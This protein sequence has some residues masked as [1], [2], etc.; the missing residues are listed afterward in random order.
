MK[1]RILHVVG[2]S[3]YGGGSLIIIHLALAAMEAGFDVDV[4]ATDPVFQDALKSSGIGVVPLDCIWRDIRPFKDIIGLWRLR[5]YLIAHP[6][7][8]VH[9]HTSKAG[10]VGRAAAWMARIP[11]IVHTVH[12][13]AFHE[14]SS[15]AALRVYS[16]LERRA[17]HW[18][19]RLVTVSRFHRQWAL[20]LGIGYPGQVVAIP[21]GIPATRVAQSR[22]SEAVRAELGIAPE[23]VMVMA[24]GRLAPQ[25]GLEYLVEA[26][27]LLVR[28]GRRNAVLVIVGD[29][30][31]REP[32]QQKCRELGIDERVVFTGYRADIGDIVSASDYIALPSLREGLS[33]ALLEAMA[34]GKPIVT[35]SIGSNLEATDNGRVASIVPPKDAVALAD[36]IEHLLQNPDVAAG[37]GRA[38]RERFDACYTERRMLDAYVSLYHELLDERGKA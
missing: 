2:D 8:I 9:T 20:E 24:P 31:L 12:G 34:A 11:A 23:T 38:A 28:R 33:I 7:D 18:C 37:L 21:N 15:R 5:R 19:H 36:S 14:E 13:F 30:V 35:T 26:F 32:L 22:S 25:K 29:G 16:F 17:A 6:Y 4:L 1:K 10:F 27:E 3:K